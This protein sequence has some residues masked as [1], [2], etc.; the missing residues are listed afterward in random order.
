MGNRYHIPDPTKQH[1][2]IQ[3]TNLRQKDVAERFGVTPRTVRRI[4]KNALEKGSVSCPPLVDGRPGELS[5][6]DI[7]V[8]NPNFT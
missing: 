5:W 3:S 7:I 2:F 8:R 4:V 6:Q 1:I